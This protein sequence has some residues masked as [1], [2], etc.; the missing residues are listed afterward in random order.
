MTTDEI[1][2]ATEWFSSA[3]FSRLNTA[4]ETHLDLSKIIENAITDTESQMSIEELDTVRQNSAAQSAS[5][6]GL[7]VRAVLMRFSATPSFAKFEALRPRSMAIETAWTNEQ[8]S[9]HDA[10]IEKVTIQTLEEFTGM[11]FS[12]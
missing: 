5:A 7:E 8:K 11:D 10:E 1:A 12:E 6:I 4:M 2:V 3:A 9:D